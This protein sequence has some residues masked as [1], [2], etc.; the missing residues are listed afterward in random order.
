MIYCKIV[1]V[2]QQEFNF[3]THS[4][5]VFFTVKYT[6]DEEAIAECLRKD[7]ESH[8]LLNDRIQELQYF[9][10]TAY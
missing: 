7:Q 9:C 6:V 10:M 5:N 4:A 1:Y 8:Y 2:R 3:G